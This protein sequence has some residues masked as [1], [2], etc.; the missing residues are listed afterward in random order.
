MAGQPSSDRS[1]NGVIEGTQGR[2]VPTALA[3]TAVARP[4]DAEPHPPPGTPPPRDDVCELRC[5]G[6]HPVH[7][8]MRLRA[9]TAER[10]VLLACEHGADAHGFTPRWYTPQRVL[11]MTDRVRYRGPRLG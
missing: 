3:P 9:S 6:V 4:E 2:R 5:A 10:V 8:D 7:C 11:W 1:T